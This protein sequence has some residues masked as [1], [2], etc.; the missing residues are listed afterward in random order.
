VAIGVA[1]YDPET[2]VVLANSD[3]G[4]ANGES[5]FGQAYDLT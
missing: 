3:E 5:T 4:D 2:V 1:A